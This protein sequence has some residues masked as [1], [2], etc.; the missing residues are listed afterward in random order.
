MGVVSHMAEA[1]KRTAA[2]TKGSKFSEQRDRTCPRASARTSTCLLQA[3]NSQPG[4]CFMFVG[5]HS[6]WNRRVNARHE[7]A[8]DGQTVHRD[9]RSIG[10]K[11]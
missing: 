10:P 8:E 6:S 7:S 11:R 4:Y 1:V 2:A 3:K 5:T 9:F